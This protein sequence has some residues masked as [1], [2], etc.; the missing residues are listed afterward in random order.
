MI[1]LIKPRLEKYINVS[2]YENHSLVVVT[3]SNANQDEVI[4]YSNHIKDNVYRVFN[5]NLE[6]EPIIIS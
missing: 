5:I 1:E 4:S 3:N 6:V 2:L